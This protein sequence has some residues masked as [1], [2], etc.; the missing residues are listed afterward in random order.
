MPPGQHQQKSILESLRGLL[1]DFLRNSGIS[2]P[3]TLDVACDL[4]FLLSAYREEE[5]PLFPEVYLLGP[6]PSGDVLAAIAP[7]AERV[8]IGTAPLDHRAAARALESCAGLATG[9]W[10]IFLRR[11][12][13][14][15]AFG[16]F[17]AYQLPFSVSADESLASPGNSEAGVVLLRNCAAHCVELQDGTGQHLELSLSAA[18]PASEPMATQIQGLAAAVCEDVGAA[19]R[20]TM[21]GYLT[22]LLGDLCKQAHGVLIGVVPHTTVRLPRSLDDGVLL[23]KPVGLVDALRDV[24]GRHSDVSL[25]TLKARESLLQG[26]ITSDGVTVLA[27]DASVRGFRIFIKATARENRELG[28]RGVTGGARSRAYHVMQMRLGRPF[29]AV[30]IRSQDGGTAF[31]RVM[32]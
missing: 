16:V 18:P 10:A 21:Y 6:R 31:A 5:V 15:F 1:A 13:E 8:P 3:I 11:E 23:P 26:M 19:L 4:V 28:E 32:P 22:R 14:R 7:G 30:F 9:G 24:L 17:R 27:T 25:A 29:R 2:C 12:P 20:P